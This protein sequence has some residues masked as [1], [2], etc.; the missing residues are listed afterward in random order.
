MSVHQIPEAQCDTCPDSTIA[1]HHGDTEQD[2]LDAITADGWVFA[3][4]LLTCPACSAPIDL[5]S[6]PTTQET[7]P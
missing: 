3:G 4:G 7:H 6:S 5:V 1:G 2:L